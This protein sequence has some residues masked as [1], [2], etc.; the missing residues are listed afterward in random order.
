LQYQL[1]NNVDQVVH[2]I[3]LALMLI[4][5]LMLV[6]Y[7][8][9]CMCEYNLSTVWRKLK[10]WENLHWYSHVYGLIFIFDCLQKIIILCYG[11]RKVWCIWRFSYFFYT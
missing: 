1:P 11:R 5:L 6:D 10:L 4:L 3:S 9:D 7:S 2:L 8:N